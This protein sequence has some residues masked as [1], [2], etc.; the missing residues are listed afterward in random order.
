MAFFFDEH[1]PVVFQQL[2][3]IDFQVY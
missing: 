3:Y 2:K 1:G